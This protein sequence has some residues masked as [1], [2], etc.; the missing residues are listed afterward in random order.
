MSL[1]LDAAYRARLAQLRDVAPRSP[2]VPLFAG[3]ARIGSVEPHVFP[4][5]ALPA[6]VIREH[7]GGWQV[8]G[9][10]TATL[11]TIARALHKAGIA[12]PSW[13]DE[14]LAVTDEAGRVLGS[15][16][17]AAVRPLGVT[18]F[19]VHMAGFAPD[20][21]H[22][23][24]QRSFSKA[25]DP[26]LWDTLMG[27]MIPLSETLATAL[28]RETMEEAG[29]ALSQ[30]RDLRHGGRVLT[31]RP[32]PPAG[33]IVEWIDWYRCTVPDG[34]AP[35]NLDGEVEQFALLDEPAVAAKLMNDEFTLEAAVVLTESAG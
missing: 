32:T 10:L 19:A 24:Q 6:S 25:N 18:T 28:E 35:R 31:R 7:G 3:D 4:H 23:V 21:R 15:V 9:E 12:H 20:G 1:A 26:G 13:R 14:Q 8:Q 16:E 2:R 34:V 5:L 29:L 27:G 22:W 11:D 33:Y 30:L 17:R